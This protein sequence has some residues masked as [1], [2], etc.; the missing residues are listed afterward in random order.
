[1]AALTA[2]RKVIARKPNP[3]DMGLEVS[4]TVAATTVIYEGAFVKIDVDR[5]RSS[6]EL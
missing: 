6:D 5:R 3:Y 4:Y 2:G 1:M